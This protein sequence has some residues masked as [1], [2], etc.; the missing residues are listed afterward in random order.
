MHSFAHCRQEK[1]GVKKAGFGGIIVLLNG[2]PPTH[3]Y[4]PLG[5]VKA[6]K[7]NLGPL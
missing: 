5:K 6:Y 1:D 4:I 2:G 7:A 3:D